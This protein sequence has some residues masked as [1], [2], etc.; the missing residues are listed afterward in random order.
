VGGWLL[1]GTFVWKLQPVTPPP[2]SCCWCYRWCCLHPLSGYAFRKLGKWAS[3][4]SDYLQSLAL[5]PGNVKT[6]N[7]LG[8]SYAKGGDYENAIKSYTTVS[9][10]GCGAVTGA[11]VAVILA[12]LW[13][14]ERTSWVCAPSAGYRDRPLEQPRVSQPRDKL[15]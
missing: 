9:W 5:A 2:C 15:R 10:E 12:G 4:I 8:Y 3:A 11:A 1:K 13:C 7:N 6:Y 14:R